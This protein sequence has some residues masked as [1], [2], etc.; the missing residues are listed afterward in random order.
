M[1]GKELFI[2]EK[3]GCEEYGYSYKLRYP[4]GRTMWAMSVEAYLIEGSWRL[5][6]RGPGWDLLPRGR[7]P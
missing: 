3:A 5:I 6:H 4:D 1:T 2:E 7:L